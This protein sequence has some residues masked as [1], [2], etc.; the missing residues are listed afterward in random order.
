MSS[1][2][3]TADATRAETRLVVPFAD[4][5]AEQKML[6]GGK[7]ANLA[8]MTR[9]GLPVPQGFIVTTDAC[10]H[11]LDAG[12]V[13]EDL[14]RQVADALHQLETD[15]GRRLGDPDRPLL[16][17]VRSGAPFSM[18]GMMDTVLD[19]GATPATMDGL[20]RMGDAWFAQD[21][22]RRFLEMFGRVVLG[23]DEAAFNAGV[24]AAVEAAG[25]ATERDL[26]VEQLEALVAAHRQAIADAGA[27]L[28]E[29]PH[30]QLTLAIEAVFRSWNG[31]RARAYRKVERIPDDLG[32]AVNVQMM[33]FGNL[34]D[35]SA[36]GVAFTRDPATGENVPYGDFLIGAQGEDVVAGTRT[37]E[38]LAQLADEFPAQHKELLDHLDTLEHHY[39]DLCDIEFTIERGTLYMLQTRVGKRSAAAALRMAVEMVDEGLI[40]QTEAVRR[41]TPRQLEALLH[42]RFAPGAPA[43]LTTGL[44]ASPGAA[45]G[46]IVLSSVEARDR[47]LAGEAV[48]LVRPETSPEDLE[49]MVASAGL[50]TARGG[51][52]SHAAVVA[53]GLG[54]PAV[55]GAAEVKID[56]EAGTVTINGT[57]LHADDV[58][59]ID[60]T[61]GAV[62]AG[63]VELEIPEDDPKVAQL[64]GWADTHRTLHVFANADTPDD[65][66]RAL[67]AGAEGIGLCRTEHQFL[68]DRLPLIQQMI[69]SRTPDTEA[70]A[71]V[72]LEA[73]QRDDFTQLFEVMDGK[74]VVIRL[75]DPP[76]HEFLPDL[77]SLHIK[78]ALGELTE[79]EREMMEAAEALKE[80]DPM[81]GVRGIRLGVLRPEVYRAQVRAV[82]GAAVDR[83]RAGGDPK[84]EIMLPLI[85]TSQELE[86]GVAL[87]HDVARGVLAETDVEVDYT[88]ATM[89]ETPRAAL[90]AG[91]LAPHVDAFSFGTNDLTQ[92]TFGLSRD[93]VEATYIPRGLE[94]QLLPVDPFRTLDPDGVGRLIELAVTE[95]REVKPELV[96]GIC[97]EHGG[98]PDSIALAHRVGLTH[99]SCSSS[100]LEV[101]RLAAAHAAL[102]L[103]GPSSTA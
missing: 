34:G 85:G 63:E 25:V 23:V 28:P 56:S 50:L 5:R 87:I 45:V 15:T 80:H 47:G 9:I 103:G 64:L 36:T 41:V 97:G 16:L 88:V 3:S 90:R 37:V 102:G 31:A 73:A 59:S 43:P 1:S 21:A 92:L 68:G 60:G 66:R 20:T 70:A 62:V 69:L 12:A 65:A 53:R 39:R 95:G 22:A 61:S 75:L 18:P 19:L 67:A 24:E 77:E 76:L 81:L 58:I 11:Y 98:D 17:S 48:V 49:G 96:T 35:D 52:V 13:P 71:L 54:K 86:W 99:V 83:V 10:R 51:L 94:L 2:T 32:T 27:T 29:D 33:V 4:G 79:E 6:L 84:P 82:I 14:A 7:G 91:R 89:I 78:R 57:V 42:P 40:D 101:A 38:P 46:K 55:C 72:E 44:A 8:E 26:T 93:D 30:E 100:R 74:R